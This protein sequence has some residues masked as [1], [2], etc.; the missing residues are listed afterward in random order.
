MA[1]GHVERRLALHV[2]TIR[3][4]ESRERRGSLEPPDQ[5]IEIRGNFFDR[6]REPLLRLGTIPAAGGADGKPSAMCERGAVLWGPQQDRGVLD[7]ELAVAARFDVDEH[8]LRHVTR[9]REF[10]GQT[11]DGQAIRDIRGFHG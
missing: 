8:E 4:E 10:P 3:L 9:S 1:I 5:R 7:G 6:L 11:N 2:L